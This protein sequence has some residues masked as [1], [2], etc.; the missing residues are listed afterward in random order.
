MTGRYK[1]YP[2]YMDSGVDWLGKV[3]TSWKVMPCRGVVRNIVEKNE[4]I[5]DQNYLSLM[6]NVGVIKYEDKGDI[7]N[8]KP[9]DLSKCKIV[10]KGNLVINSMNYAIGSYGMSEYD[11]V[12]SSVYI[13]LDA[14]GEAVERRFALRVF[15]NKPFQKYLSTFGNG[16]L[17]HRAA[18][19][20]DDIKSAYIA[21]PSKEEQLAILN[22]LDYETAKIDTLIEKQQ[23]LI[24]LLKEKRQ[25][26]ISHAVTKGL[27]PNAKMRD[28]GVEWFDKLPGH[29]NVG[30]LGYYSFISNGATP[31][32]EN[33]AYW[34]SGT[35]G[36]LNSSKVNDIY[37]READQFI[38]PLAVS[39]TSVKKVKENDLVIAI[40]GEGQTRGRVAICK[41]SVTINQHLAGMSI[42]NESLHYE[43]LFYWLTSQYERVRFESSGAGSTKGAIT[44][45]DIKSYPLPVPPL[46]EQKAIVSHIVAITEKVD[47]LINLSEKQ[48]LFSQERRTA[49]ISAAVTGKIDVRNWQALN[50]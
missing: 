38:T 32:R 18:I 46:D 49:L 43:Y 10:K 1:S 14:N 27:N 2:E 36:W 37:I 28:S 45:E 35:I 3:P 24:K 25:A 4:G 41:T 7:G 20:W 13:V 12:C 15:E 19:G 26:V 21:V 44:C 50:G 11:G 31:S 47:S 34:E 29:W 8:K 30:R 17:E 22:F 9:D 6:A 42:N 5:L 48:V 33:L 39:Q 23:Q 40:T 16:I